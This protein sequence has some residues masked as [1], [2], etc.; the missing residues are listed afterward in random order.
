MTGK[1]IGIQKKRW[2]DNIEE[3]TGMDSGSTTWAAEDK[4]TRLWDRRDWTSL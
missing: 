2:E 3:L 4:R 1:I